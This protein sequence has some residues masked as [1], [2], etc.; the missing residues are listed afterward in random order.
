MRSRFRKI[1]PIIVVLASCA[2]VPFICRAVYGYVL[3][4]VLFGALK[5]PE[6]KATL[7]QIRFAAHIELPP[8]AS[9]IEGF[10][11]GGGLRKYCSIYA[12][13]TINA[14]DLSRFVKETRVKLPLSSVT[15]SE[16][17][18]TIQDVFHEAGDPSGIYQ[19]GD[20]PVSL[21]Y[22]QS[23]LVNTVDS[24]RYTVYVIASY[25]VF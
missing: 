23:I 6:G 17:L 18:S 22:T 16:A 1:L 3:L 9:D 2:V 5:C 20:G 24:L 12:R 25:E 13:L 8:S 21:D 10:H 7:E 14:A 15:V 11:G 19:Q 4:D